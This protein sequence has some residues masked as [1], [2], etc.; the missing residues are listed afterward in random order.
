M[1]LTTPPQVTL[2]AIVCCPRRQRA[3]A[4]WCCDSSIVAR[5]S[6]CESNFWRSEEARGRG[7]AGITSCG[8]ALSPLHCS[9]SPQQLDEPDTAP[10]A[11]LHT[12]R[13]ALSRCWQES[14]AVFCSTRQRT[15]SLH[16]LH[17]AAGRAAAKEGTARI[18]EQT[19]THK[20]I[21]TSTPGIAPWH[22][23][24]KSSPL[25]FPLKHCKDVGTRAEERPVWV[26]A[27]I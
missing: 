23:S 21:H 19:G 16:S 12:R 2:Q 6:L 7:E 3:S 20:V 27:C 1:R 10:G 25:N 14:F 13:S 8:L 11:V 15:V 17:W 26:G 22:T 24:V 4:T 5:L 9:S 18:E